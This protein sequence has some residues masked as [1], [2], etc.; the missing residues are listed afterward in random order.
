MSLGGNKEAKE[1]FLHRRDFQFPFTSPHHSLFIFLLAEGPLCP[2]TVALGTRNE[3]DM[4]PAL[5]K[6]IANFSLSM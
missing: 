2:P 6:P 3:D 1:G 5:Q 4:V